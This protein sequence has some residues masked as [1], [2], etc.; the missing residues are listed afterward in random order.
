MVHKVK[1]SARV[2][3]VGKSALDSQA[4]VADVVVVLVEEKWSTLLDIEENSIGIEPIALGNGLIEFL[5]RHVCIVMMSQLLN[6]VVLPALLI[7]TV[8]VN[9]VSSV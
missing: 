6:G 5:F 3:V 2:D 1:L 4:H 9:V 7:S 8:P